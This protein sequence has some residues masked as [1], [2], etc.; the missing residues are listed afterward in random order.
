MLKGRARKKYDYSVK[1]PR[2][3]QQIVEDEQR[4]LFSSRTRDISSLLKLFH[5]NL[6]RI[7]RQ[8]GDII[9]ECMI[10]PYH[11]KII[12]REMSYCEKKLRKHLNW[13]TVDFL[14][15]PAGARELN[16][17]TKEIKRRSNFF[18]SPPSYVFEARQTRTPN[19][20][21]SNPFGHGVF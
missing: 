11:R 10:G 12:F 13:S 4:R 15:D 21:S 6:K 20:E 19:M 18:V 16:S 7:Y 9:I 14:K 3:L 2:R 17:V 1:S 5:H 8:D